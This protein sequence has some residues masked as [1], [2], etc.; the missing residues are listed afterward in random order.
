MKLEW[1][2]ALWGAFTG[3]IACAHLL[4][5]WFHDR[6]RLK[7]RGEMSVDY[8]RRLVVLLTIR[9]VNLGRRPVRISK[10]AALLSK[11]SMPV[12]PGTPPERAAE[13]Q[14]GLVS[15]EIC[16][17]GDRGEQ[18][19]ELSPDGGQHTWELPLPQHVNFV[20]YAKRGEK[21]GK[22]YVMLTSG[23]KVFFGFPLLE[24]A[25]W[26]QMSELRENA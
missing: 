6:G 18:V 20:C 19:V 26:H 16:P 24:D 11:S 22:G 13:L 25:V 23:K 15:S 5:G 2:L 10:V 14:K 8:G 1:Y 12:P 3:T 4:R 21:L 7:V 9:A 17:S